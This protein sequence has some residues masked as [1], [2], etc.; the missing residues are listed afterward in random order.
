MKTMTAPAFVGPGGMAIYL[1]ELPPL[2]G[3]QF[4]DVVG[5][6]ADGLFVMRVPSQSMA[7]VELL[8]ESLGWTA[9]NPGSQ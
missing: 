7:A 6:D 8:A 2:R 5:Y 9:T 3:K 1:E 4:F